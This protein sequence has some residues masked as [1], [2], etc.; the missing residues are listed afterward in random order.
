MF[1][2]YDV[3]RLVKPI[4]S[5]QELLPG[6]KGTILI[7]YDTKEEPFYEVEFVDNQGNSLAIVTV[8]NEFLE[9]YS[10]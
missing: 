3:V 8:P 10:K 9:I 7:I 2:I 4:V 6:T 5:K 1:Q